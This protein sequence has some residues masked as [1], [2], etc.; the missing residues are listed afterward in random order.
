MPKL[1]R[2]KA[3]E[4]KKKQAK[5]Q[6]KKQAS[7]PAVE[8]PP[9]VVDPPAPVVMDPPAPVVEEAPATEIP[10]AVQVDLVAATS[11][12]IIVAV[13]IGKVH[14]EPSGLPEVQRKRKSED[15]SNGKAPKKRALATAAVACGR[16]Q[17]KEAAP[18]EPFVKSTQT[19][20]AVKTALAWRKKQQGIIKKPHAVSTGSRKKLVGSIVYQEKEQEKEKAV[21]PVTKFQGQVGN[22]FANGEGHKQITEIF[23]S[24]IKFGSD[25][26]VLER[27]DDPDWEQIE[28]DVLKL[29]KKTKTSMLY[30]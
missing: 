17:S 20:V 11:D 26:E 2:S 13:C 1:S 30:H 18:K 19:A 25:L 3:A 10:S 21:N 24:M 8:A 27:Q 7:M 22:L 28:K 16:V 14:D 12:G 4:R 9:A 5:E 29:V 6:A 23:E 15:T